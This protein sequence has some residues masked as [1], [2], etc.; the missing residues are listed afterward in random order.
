MSAHSH[1]SVPCPLCS[2]SPAMPVISL[3]LLCLLLDLSLIIV[4]LLLC[5][6]QD[7]SHSSVTSV[8]LSSLMRQF[9]T[10]VNF[11]LLTSGSVFF[12][13]E[14]K[15]SF[16][17][18]CLGLIIHCCNLSYL[19]HVSFSKPSPTLASFTTYLKASDK[20]TKMQMKLCHFPY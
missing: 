19:D 6:F 14:K 11:T 16:L 3:N 8:I 5:A 1:T 12:S 2:I 7:P 4:S 10:W 17:S 13:S 15:A 9:T 18:V 20:L